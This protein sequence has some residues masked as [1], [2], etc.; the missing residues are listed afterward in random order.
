MC[1]PENTKSDK[2]HLGGW[3][4]NGD[5]YTYLPD[6][7]GYLCIKYNVR[8]VL[9]VGCGIGNNLQ[10]F[11]DYRKARTLGIE[12]D[13][14]AINNSKLKDIIICHDYTQSEMRLKGFYDL[15]ICT[16]F[17]EHVHQKFEHNWLTTLKSCAYVLFSHGLPGQ[18]GYH[19]VNCQ[20]SQYW[21]DRFRYYNF[22]ADQQETE[23]LRSTNLILK[24]PWCRDSLIFFKN[25]ENF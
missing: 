10:W 9:D 25:N 24:S 23:I 20:E 13:L 18:D 4:E 15:G 6:V 1:M 7:W 19:H 14:E 17:A 3:I 11:R 2:K 16:E 8:S 21:I 5:P 22:S 12:G